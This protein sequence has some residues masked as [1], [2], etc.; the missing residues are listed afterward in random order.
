MNHAKGWRTWFECI[1]DLENSGIH[2]QTSERQKNNE[3]KV[4]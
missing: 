2:P 4:K 3:R 1:N